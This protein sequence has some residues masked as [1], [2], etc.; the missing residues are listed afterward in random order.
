M[1]N[2]IRRSPSRYLRTLSFIEL[3]GGTDKGTQTLIQ[4]YVIEIPME[5]YIINKVEENQG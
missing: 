1:V 4:L 5:K 2:F 3:R